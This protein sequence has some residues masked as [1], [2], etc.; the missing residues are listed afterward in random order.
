M[1]AVERDGKFIKSPGMCPN[2]GELQFCVFHQRTELG[3]Y[4]FHC[5]CH[6]KATGTVVTLIYKFQVYR[7]HLILFLGP[8]GAQF[9]KQNL[10]LS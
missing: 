9:I 3:Q 4:L 7:L 5:L 1:E 6:I 8:K 2:L 10:F